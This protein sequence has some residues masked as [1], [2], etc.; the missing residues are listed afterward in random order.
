MYP[1]YRTPRAKVATAIPAN[2]R[3]ILLLAGRRDRNSVQGLFARDGSET[4][5]AAI[6]SVHSPRLPSRSLADI[7][8]KDTA[9]VMATKR[10][11]IEIGWVIAGELDE[12]DYDAVRQARAELL[13]VLNQWFSE[14]SWRMPVVRRPEM[15]TTSRTQPVVLLDRG[16][17]EL[18]SYHWDFALVV[19]EADF[20]TYYKPFALA[21]VS[22]GLDIGLI[23]TSRVDPA[24]HDENIS[25]EQRVAIL[26]GRI[27][28]LGLHVLGHLAGLRH[29]GSSDNLMLDLT[30]VSDLDRMNEI[31]AG[32]RT[33]LTES[34]RQIADTR[35]EEEENG[36]MR[37]A[38]RFYVRSAW[39]NRHEVYDAVRQARPWEF[40]RRLA[41]LTTAA[42]SAGVVFM[43]TA[44][45]WDFALSQST[46]MTI[47]LAVLAL[48]LTTTYVAR[49]QQ[50]FVRRK[51]RK[52]S[53]QT[54]ISNVATA[55]IV[56]AGMTTTFLG[57]F[58]AILL[59][60]RV[61]F[62]EDLVVVWAHDL[63]T[64]TWSHYLKFAGVA[65]SLAL[66]IGALGASFEEQ[67]H[68]RHITFVDEET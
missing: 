42:V 37:S 13:D 6:E 39:M 24:A 33:K 30:D 9:L 65:A 1:E 22:R 12:V 47:V 63:T 3:H 11:T 10:S 56:L 51:R 41:R 36:L 53:E 64:V 4:S 43:M 57:M 32:Q 35:L 38:L 54:V 48:T 17:E 20:V 25:R 21:I 68:V 58:V 28:S 23:S 67:H 61:L 59:A 16:H 19:T 8:R 14:F 44:E 15:V 66:T 5:D 62:P 2:D 26:A 52:L 31:N 40:P 27:Q 29:D 55:S 60:G 46:S 45:A 49:R 18:A 7:Y 34:L 50:L